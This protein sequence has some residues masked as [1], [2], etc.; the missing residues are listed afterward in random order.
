M[1]RRILAVRLFGLSARGHSDR[2]GGGEGKRAVHWRFLQV[3]WR[4]W[5]DSASLATLATYRADLT[6]PVQ[7][8]Q[9]GRAMIGVR[10]IA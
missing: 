4:R 6:P 8:R 9:I 2:Q 7:T 5:R 1:G 10:H 3:C